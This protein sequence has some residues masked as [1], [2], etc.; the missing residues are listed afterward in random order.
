MPEVTLLAGRAPTL[1]A[2]TVP[3]EILEPIKFVKFAPLI[4][5]SV[6]V[7]FAAGRLVRDAPEP[8]KV[9]AVMTPLSFTSPSTSNFD[10]GIVELIP[11][12]PAVKNVL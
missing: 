4:A 3:D 7:R 12:L 5:G 6:P 10:V 2:A 8:L 9:V 11:T 1:A